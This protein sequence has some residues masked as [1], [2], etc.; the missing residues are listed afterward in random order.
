[1]NTRELIDRV[2]EADPSGLK[3]VWLEINT[4]DAY[5]GRTYT[6]PADR[7]RVDDDGDVVVTGETQ[8]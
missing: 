3:E 2:R 8:P 1:M 6:D 4:G 7:I 5:E